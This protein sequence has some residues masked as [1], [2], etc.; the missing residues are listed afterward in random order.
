MKKLFYLCV[1]MSVTLFAC[2][3]DD[4]GEDVGTES[5]RTSV[6]KSGSYVASEVDGGEPGAY[7]YTESGEIV[8]GGDSVRNEAKPGLLTAGEW[9]DLDN[10]GYWVKLLN[11]NNFYDKP[12]YWQF[13]PKN[14]V[15]VRVTD[16]DNNAVPNVPV[17]LMS[18]GNAEFSAK[19]DNSGLAGLICS[20]ARRCSRI[21]L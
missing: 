21:I 10:W 20:T 7:D 15:A 6:E 1:A 17:T 5:G 2:D 8:G 14:L 9:S 4:G 13:F 12:K 19:T 3:G 16:A 18:G 11:N